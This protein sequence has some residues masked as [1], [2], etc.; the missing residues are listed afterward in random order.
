MNASYTFNLTPPDLDNIKLKYAINTA[1]GSGSWVTSVP[2]IAGDIGDEPSISVNERT[3]GF[4]VTSLDPTNNQ[5]VY[6]PPIP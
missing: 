5:I 1:A 6:T 3:G 4:H 2:S